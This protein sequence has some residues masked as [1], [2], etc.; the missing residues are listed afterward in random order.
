M[1]ILLSTRSKVKKPRPHA[2]CNVPS[3]MEIQ[4]PRE[5]TTIEVCKV[6]D[7]RHFR[8]RLDPGKLNTK[9]M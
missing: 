3:N 9:M 8:V 4:K 2:C 1:G 5:D 7:C 6:C